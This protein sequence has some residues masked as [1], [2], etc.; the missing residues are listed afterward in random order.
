M[1]RK[2]WRIAAAMLVSVA[3]GMMPHASAATKFKT[4]HRFT[5]TDGGYSSSDLI[6]DVQ[7]NLYG[8]TLYDGLNDGGTV[9]ELTP[10]ADG[11]WTE[12]VLYDF[13]S[14]TNCSDGQTP[15]SRLVL[16]SGGTLY[17][18]TL[19][20]GRFGKGTVFALTSQSDGTWNER[21]IYDFCP[22]GG[23]CL[24]GDFPTALTFDQVGK[25]YGTAQGGGAFHGGT[26]FEL[27]AGS[28]GNWTQQVLYNFCSGGKCNDG[29]T[30]VSLA[31]DSTGRLFGTTV[32]GGLH[33][34]QCGVVF[35]L[36]PN[37]DG[38]WR[39]AALHQFGSKGDG[40]SPRAGLVFDGTG[41]LYGTTSLGGGFRAGT[42]FEIM[43]KR[44]GKWKEKLLYSFTGGRDGSNP[45]STLTFD[46][47]GN[48]HG[49]ATSGGDRNA[50]SGAGCGTVFKLA[51]TPDGTWSET[52]LHR[53]HDHP[54]GFP[55]AGVVFDVVGNLYGTTSGA[56]TVGSVYEIAP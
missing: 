7:G 3:V 49:T 47:T 17:G 33:I 48:L 53:F 29:S 35:I 26:V 42:V 13:C 14:E 16:D 2:S 40:K 46:Q 28:N 51:R 11:T 34:C 5:G 31:F 10:Q 36:V 24:D 15:Y 18:S 43:P 39:E 4:I 8:T 50:C 25:L 22:S 32:Y 30:P 52:V 9:F 45:L 56:T 38:T 44:L 41:N 54:G 21:V 55:G 1:S 20:G 23:T 37:S 12:T 19:Y 6:F 27:M